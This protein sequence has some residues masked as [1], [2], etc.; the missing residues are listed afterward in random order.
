MSIRNSHPPPVQTTAS[1]ESRL[2]YVLR[3][4]AAHK[5]TASLVVGPAA[6]T[7][8]R[9]G[10]CLYEPTSNLALLTVGTVVPAAQKNE[11]RTEVDELD[12]QVI[13]NVL[14][15]HVVEAF[16]EGLIRELASDFSKIYELSSDRSDV[17]ELSLALNK[18][19]LHVGVLSS[20]I[21]IQKQRSKNKVEYRVDFWVSRR[22]TGAGAIA[23]PVRSYTSAPYFLGMDG[24]LKDRI[25]LVELH[26]NF[27]KA[28]PD[29][30]G[31][32]V[33]AIRNLKYMKQL[34]IFSQEDEWRTRSS[35][36]KCGQPWT[37][38]RL[39]RRRVCPPR[40]WS[41]KLSRRLSPNCITQL[42]KTCSS[43]N[44]AGL[45]N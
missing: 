40:Y 23:G 21:A 41:L 39:V 8:A 7:V 45:P 12:M 9:P 4:G 38:R 31:K 27:N 20:R 35:I 26:N 6:G 14:H 42:C 17:I 11:V 24:I 5:P 22:D 19:I 29:Q 3:V 2:Q 15:E 43:T 10:H 13:K 37:R 36:E 1:N 30:P 33:A 28:D 18:Q 34:T 32:F 44:R 16:A 25:D